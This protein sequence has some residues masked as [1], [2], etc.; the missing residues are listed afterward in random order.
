MLHAIWNNP[1]EREK[2]PC[3]CI[4]KK[5]IIAE[6]IS[7]RKING[8]GI[9]DTDGGPDFKWNQKFVFYHKKNYTV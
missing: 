6:A 5:N 3:C 8:S 4:R 7:L 2:K 9:Q 1:A